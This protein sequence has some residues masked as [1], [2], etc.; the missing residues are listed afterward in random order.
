M[1]SLEWISFALDVL[2]V[3][4]GLAAYL[5]RPRIGGQMAQGLRVLLVGVV[6]LGFAHLL[7]T[8]LFT[9][10]HVAQDW[11]EIAHRLIVGSGF[12]LVII[13]FLIM[14]RAVEE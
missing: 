9:L 13:G 11:N 5:A 12:V 3:V 2:L 10:F 6:V 1:P 8:L 4:A 14:R 7:E